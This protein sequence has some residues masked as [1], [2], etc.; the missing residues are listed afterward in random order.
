MKPI[1]E[2]RNLSKKFIIDHERQAYLSLGEKFKSVFSGKRT[3]EEFWALTNVDFKVERGET[4]GIIG[5]NG[6]GKSTI[7][8]ILSKIT[9]PTSGSIITRGRI[10]SLLEVG[11]GFHPELTGRENIYLNGSILGMKR[12]EIGMKFDEIVDFSGVEKFL[13]TPL[14][15]YSS[16]MQLRLAFAVA[17]FLE[18]EILV[19]DEVLAVGDMEFQKKCLRQMETVSK[20]G[21]TILFVSH[22]M[23]AVKR[24]CSKGVLLREGK[25]DYIGTVN[26][27]I[28]KYSS[29]FDD[30]QTSFDVDFKL[31]NDVPGFAYRIE[32]ENE[33]GQP[34]NNFS[35]GQPWQV[36]VFYKMI[37]KTPGVIVALGILTN[38]DLGLRTSWSTP[39]D[40]EVGE[41]E[42]VF[43]EKCLW[44]GSGSYKLIIGL[45]SR[46]VPFQYMENVAV[47]RISDEVVADVSNIK[48]TKGVG[49]VLNPMEI[50]INKINRN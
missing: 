43:T 41:Y 45:S 21:R 38:E 34:F 17:A 26:S 18:P 31:S 4:I 16:G 12:K 13:D 14:K 3:K 5:K 42:A 32:I 15:R 7:L 49:I 35:V 40:L 8:K 37:S 2:V 29:I 27:A 20:S 22:N 44:L 19:I 39:Q 48:F 10:A 25:V 46:M 50:Q 36:R 28:D 6:A 30:I 9:P 1:I 11:T 24:L 33:Q 23:A 47:L